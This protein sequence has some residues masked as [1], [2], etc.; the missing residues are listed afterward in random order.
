[1]LMSEWPSAAPA[2]VQGLGGHARKQL[3]RQ[4]IMHS[5]AVDIFCG[6]VEQVGMELYEDDAL[7]HASQAQLAHR[8]PGSS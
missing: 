6:T 2:P 3:P 1:M 8:Q 5:T 7:N 4:H